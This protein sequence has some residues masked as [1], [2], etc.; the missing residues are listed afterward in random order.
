MFYTK[1]EIA[2]G[3][4]IRT[5]ITSENVFTICPDCGEEFQIDLADVVDEDGELDLYGLSICCP[6]CSKTTT[7][8]PRERELHFEKWQPDESQRFRILAYFKDF[9]EST[10]NTCGEDDDQTREAL[11][12]YQLVRQHSLQSCKPD[13]QDHF[14][15]MFY[16]VGGQ[17]ETYYAGEPEIIDLINLTV[18][19]DPIGGENCAGSKDQH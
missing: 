17:P 6:S 16:Y 1:A 3:V 11:N 10:K 5:E 2:E 13:I 18:S 12:L 14:A 7:A 15:D 4:T 9:Y 8:S 19:P